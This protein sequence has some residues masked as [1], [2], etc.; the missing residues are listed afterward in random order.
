MPKEEP[1]PNG[2][3]PQRNIPEEFHFER[4]PVVCWHCNQAFEHFVIEVIDNLT[5]MRCGNG[6]IANIRIACM[7]CGRVTS[8]DVN[9]KKL[10]KMAVTYG[11]LS[12]KLSGHQPE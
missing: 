7:R 8:W 12:L 3:T 5:Q 11:E 6:L 2:R 10:E 9:T 4:G 1:N